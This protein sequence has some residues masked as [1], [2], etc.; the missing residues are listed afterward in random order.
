MPTEGI[1]DND[2]IQ[3]IND[4]MIPQGAYSV[5][6]NGKLYV[7]SI[8]YSTKEIV[9]L[10]KVAAKNTEEIKIEFPD[11]W[12]HQYDNQE[13]TLIDVPNGSA[14][15]N[16]VQAEI[17]K[18]Y[19]QAQIKRLQRIQA[20]ALWRRYY[21]EKVAMTHRNGN[22]NEMFLFHGT[23]NNPPSEIYN[24]K[25]GFDTIYANIGG[26]CGGGTYFSP[27]AS[28]S[29]SSYYHVGPQ[30][31][32]VFFARVLVGVPGPLD[33]SRLKPSI[34]PATRRPYDS[35]QNGAAMFVV[36]TNNKCYPSYLF[37]F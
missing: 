19:R 13:V 31:N 24:G 28:Y 23:R 6:A 32:E 2:K 27:Q 34:N 3:L 17:N 21:L 8:C 16:I 35:V 18:T 20:K 1:I 30:G 33:E 26:S 11:D 29:C 4:I 9:E 15:W 10:A 7:L 37:T 14:K 5:F 22:P 12:D 36:Y 25:Q